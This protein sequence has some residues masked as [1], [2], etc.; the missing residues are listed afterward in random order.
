M[1]NLALEKHGK[2]AKRDYE[3]NKFIKM[4]PRTQAYIVKLLLSKL[5]P[6]KGLIQEDD[7]GRSFHCILGLIYHC[8]ILYFI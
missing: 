2:E 5:L 1:L 4:A 3:L 6:D 8:R 7:F